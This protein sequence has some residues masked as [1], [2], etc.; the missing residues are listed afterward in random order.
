M[1]NHPNGK[2]N[3]TE[4][5]EGYENDYR[6]QRNEKVLADDSASPLAQAKRGKK[7]FQAIMHQHDIGLFERGI[8]PAGAHGHTDVCGGQA[9][10][11]VDSITNHGDAFAA[12]RERS[13]F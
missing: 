6:P 4:Q 5:G 10:G 9:G 13:D 11:I 12:F 1:A 2:G 3:F 7:V 8:G